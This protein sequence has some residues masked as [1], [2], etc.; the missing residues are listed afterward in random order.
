MVENQGARSGVQ[1]V[2][3]ASA[4]LL[5][6][7]DTP[8]GASLSALSAVVGLHKSTARRLLVTLSHMGLV[9]QMPPDDLYT[10][11]PRMPALGAAAAPTEKP[12]GQ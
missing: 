9:R 10:L 6:L 3:R 7:G 12:I 11:G 8:Q 2:E 1:S 4:L 5:A